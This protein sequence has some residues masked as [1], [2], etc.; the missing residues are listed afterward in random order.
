MNFIFHPS[1]FIMN[2][3]ENDYER[4]AAMIHSDSS[5]VG[6]D[7]KKTHIMLLYMVEQMQAKLE[8]MELRLA[9][10]EE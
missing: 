10:L 9:A 8:Q 4:I 7:A 5:P 6:I 3:P 1:S 2:I